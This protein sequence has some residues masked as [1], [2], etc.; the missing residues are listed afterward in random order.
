MSTR[1]E[2]KRLAKA[3]TAQIREA[4]ASIEA[5]QAVIVA[6]RDRIET[7]FRTYCPYT[8]ASPSRNLREVDGSSVV[9]TRVY[10]SEKA[11]G[12][13]RGNGYG[14]KGELRRKYI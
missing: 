6:E 14:G 8:L 2:R 12:P 11:F 1:N 10:P 4:L 7:S 9:A 13:L 3:R 5:A